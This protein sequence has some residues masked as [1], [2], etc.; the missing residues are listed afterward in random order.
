[1]ASLLRSLL[2]KTAWGIDGAIERILNAIDPTPDHKSTRP[3]PRTAEPQASKTSNARSSDLPTT[4]AQTR[5]KTPDTLRTTPIGTGQTDSTPAEIAQAAV[6]PEPS[7]NGGPASKTPAL[8]G[9]SG[10]LSTPEK[11]PTDLPTAPSPTAALT[12]ESEPESPAGEA[13]LPI[14]V[15]ATP[16]KPRQLDELLAPVREKNAQVVGLELL[17]EEAA[18]ITTECAPKIQLEPATTLIT[19]IRTVMEAGQWHPWSMLTF[20]PEG[21][22]LVL[23]DGQQRLLALSM[24]EDGNLSIRWTARVLDQPAGAVYASLDTVALPRPAGIRN[25]G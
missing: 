16:G 5:T 17:P 3:K 18:K 14:L 1:M 19:Q 9:I 20:A 6:E 21:E 15:P 7:A 11:K 12:R 13:R 25:A 2:S 22:R 8:S 23:A 10:P 24:I 4:V